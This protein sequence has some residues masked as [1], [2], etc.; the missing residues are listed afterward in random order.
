MNGYARANVEGVD[1]AR[2]RSVL[3]PNLDTPP[4]R[5]PPLSRDKENVGR[6]IKEDGCF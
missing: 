4:L 6:G 3:I 5:Y 2:G 1:P